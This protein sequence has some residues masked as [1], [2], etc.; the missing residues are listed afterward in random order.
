M[1][2]KS[3]EVEVVH[4]PNRQGDSIHLWLRR[5]SKRVIRVSTDAYYWG[6][7]KR[8]SRLVLGKFKIKWAFILVMIKE[9]FLF[10]F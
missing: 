9:K 10:F 5:K 3:L 8:G 4:G 2:L 7:F 1:M 6:R